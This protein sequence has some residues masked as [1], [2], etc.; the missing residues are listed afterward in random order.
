M[1]TLIAGGCGFVGLNVAQACL[2]HGQDVVLLDRNAP[3]A[4]ARNAFDALRGAWT[5]EAVDVTRE[6]AV[7]DVL[8][9]HA[10]DDVFYGAAVT[11][12]AQREREHPEQVLAVNLLGLAHVIKAAAAHGV[13]RLINVSSGSAYGDGGLARCGATSPLDEAAS[14]PQPTT[15][16]GVTKLASEGMCRRLGALTGLDTVS[17]RLA[18]IFGPWELDSGFRDTL[19]APMQAGMLALRGGTASVARCDARDWTYSRDV[20]RA[21]LALMAA[22]AHRHDLYHVS[23][24]RT[25][26]VL[27]WCEALGEHFP[28][29][30]ARLAAPGETPSVELHGDDDRECMSPRRLAE[31]IGHVV[32]GDIHETAADFAAWMKRY[33]DYWH[34]STH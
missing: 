24:G 4:A 8:R 7:K 22:P 13:R 3:P 32:P 25:C 17:V 20:A 6:A 2:E 33:P 15:L 10:V 21:L 12:G 34:R 26:S 30:R 14:R 29:F 16:Y 27:D 11:S 31:D 19:S 9:R 1:T 23:A 28:G 18:I 5:H